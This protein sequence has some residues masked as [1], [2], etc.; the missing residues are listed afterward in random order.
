VPKEGD[1]GFERVRIGMKG[2]VPAA[3]ELHDSLGGR[4]VL[5]FP[6]FRTGARVDPGEFRFTPPKGAD[7]LEEMLPAR[8]PQPG[9]AT[10]RKP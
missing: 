1:T 9:G 6:V 3:M 4:T 8:A 10:P 2:A 7:V 5:A